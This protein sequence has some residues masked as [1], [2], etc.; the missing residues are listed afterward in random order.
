MAFTLEQTGLSQ[1]NPLRRGTSHLSGNTL[2]SLQITWHFREKQRGYRDLYPRT[3]Q[4][5][6]ESVQ[7]G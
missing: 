5:N 6:V 2:P 4:G 7:L 3:W 1:Y